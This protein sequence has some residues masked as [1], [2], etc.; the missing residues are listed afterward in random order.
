MISLEG[1]RK[2]VQL[3][4]PEPVEIISKFSVLI[5]LILVKDEVHILYEKRAA[6]LR[7]QPGEI[8]FPGGRIEEGESPCR[9][10]LRETMEE[11]LL[12]EEQIELFGPG[13]FLVNLYHSVIYT[14]VGHIKTD[15][16]CIHPSHEEVERC[17]TVPLQ[18]F[19]DND[20]KGYETKVD[21]KR[22]ENFPYELIP[23]GRN[24]NFKRTGETTYFYNYEG[25][26]IWGF[27]AKMTYQFI[28]NLRKTI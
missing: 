27:T 18:F 19:L 11:L 14:F 6:T 8:S 16:S 21:I 15:F 7:N 3:K 23:G 2:S 20:P 28:K 12:P 10:A 17:F 13:D 1:I 22:G 26:I 24:Y 4:K 5:P 25:E 9:A